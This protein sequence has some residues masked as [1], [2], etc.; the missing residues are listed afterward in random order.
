VGSGSSPLSCGVFLPLPLLQAFPLL[1]AGHV[2]PLLPSLAILFVYSSHGKW[3]FPHLLWSFRPTATFTS[4]STL[5]CWVCA[6]IPVPWLVYLQFCEG[7]PSPLFSTQGAPPSLLCVFYVV[8][9]YYSVSLFSLGGGRFVQGAMLI[10]LRVVCGSTAYRLAHLWSV[11]SQAIWELP[12]GSGVGALL[13]SLFN[14]K[15][16]CYAQT[17]GVEESK[18][19]LFAVVFPVRCISSVSPRFYFRRHAFCF[20]PLATILEFL[21]FAFL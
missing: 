16:R 9:A 20:L 3:V 15:W 17:A 14:V 21:Q 7:F 19:C 11:S 10:W 1:I 13:V 4:F 18:F 8:T 5:D 6:A 12:S 2:L